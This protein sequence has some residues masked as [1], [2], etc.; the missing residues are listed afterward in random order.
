MLHENRHR[1]ESFGAMAERYDRVRPHYPAALY[2]RL[3]ELAGG[4]D[5]ATLPNVL[6][7]GCGT[8]IASRELVLRGCSVLGVETDERMAAVARGHGL[9][10]EVG[11]FEA[12]DPADRR[13]DLAVSGQAWH[14]IDPAVGPAKAASALRPGGVLAPFWN[15]GTPEA[16]LWRRLDALYE[17]LAPGLERISEPAQGERWLPSE[18]AEEPL[19]ACPALEEPRAERFA[20]PVEYTTESWIALLPTHSDHQMLDPAVRQRL[21]DAIAAEIDRYGG[22]FTVDYQTLLVSARKRPD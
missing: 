20:N 2:D 13:F 18:R 4:A 14:W 21:L 16:R 19:R 5:G 10:V 7:I 9:T 11:A 22:H 1:A 15:F 12:W 3:L 6:D 8:G 17:R